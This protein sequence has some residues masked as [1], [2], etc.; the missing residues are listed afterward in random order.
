MRNPQQESHLKRLSQSPT[1]K[2]TCSLPKN[3]LRRKIEKLPE[4]KTHKAERGT[5]YMKQC[6]SG[7]P[8]RG[9]SPN[10]SSWGGCRAW[11]S[12]GREGGREGGE[13]ALPPWSVL[14]R[15]GALFQPACQIL[16]VLLAL[17]PAR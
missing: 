3:E 7:D 1:L 5:N 11:H 16:L 6:R 13:F 8:R 10:H 15:S 2:L 14:F 17:L 9:A 12:Q 4:S